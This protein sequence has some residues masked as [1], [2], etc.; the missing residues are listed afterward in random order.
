[1]AIILVAAISS[2]VI[3]LLTLPVIIN[4]S[5]SKNLVDVPGRRKVHKKITPS[6]GGVAIFLGFITSSLI[7]IDFDSWGLIKFVLVALFVVFFI[8]VRDDLVPLRWIVKL[9]G[10]IMAASLL[11]FLFELRIHS[12]YG[13]FGVTELPLWLSYTL[14]YFT[15]IVITNSFNL[16]DGLDGLAA[17][18][19]II[20]LLAFSAWFFYVK[21]LV[22]A[23]LAMAMAGSVGA[24]LIYNWEPSKIFMGDTGALVIG[25]LLAVFTIRF[26]ELNY[27]LK[28]TELQL[29]ST[30]AIA[31][32]IIIIPL[33]DTLRV[34]ILRISKGQSPF[35]PDKSHV[36]HALLRFGFSHSKTA[37]ILGSVQ[38]FC[39]TIALILQ[40]FGDMIVVPVLICFAVGLSIL[41][42]RMLISRTGSRNLV[43][44]GDQE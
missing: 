6:L 20:S 3:A 9:L 12:L 22:F 28:N 29:G 33:I 7:W 41:L 37:V 44:E 43:S 39:I 5:L 38:I 42:E 23:T 21:D 27:A 25:L 40:K 13:V 18:L 36:H 11:I 4:F 19:G 8:G 31:T 30:I 14:T 15:I 2:F 34:F 32:S 16:I 24:F 26:M 17:L 1:M 35:K 10:Q